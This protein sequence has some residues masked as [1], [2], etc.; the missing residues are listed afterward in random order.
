MIDLDAVKRA[1]AE[2]HVIDLREDGWTM[3]HP[4]SCRPVLF[5]CP[6]N[7]AAQKSFGSSGDPG[8][9]GRYQCELADEGWLSIGDVA[10]ARADQIDVG[11]LVD[12]IEQL[13]GLLTGAHHDLPDP[14]K[15]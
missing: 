6:V 15:E 2:P 11:A 8:L 3:S 10:A 7:R 13:R 5:D 14:S 4:L 9:R 1:L 12:E